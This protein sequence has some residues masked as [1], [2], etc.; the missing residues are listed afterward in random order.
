MRRKGERT[1]TRPETRERTFKE[2]VVLPPLE[3]D[4]QIDMDF[5]DS[6]WEARDSEG[7]DDL[8]EDANGDGEE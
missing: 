3:E 8:G 6:D 7:E 2:T 4:S 5:E 1:S